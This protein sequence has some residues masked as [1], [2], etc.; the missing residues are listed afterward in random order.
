MYVYRSKFRNPTVEK[1]I[2]QTVIEQFR[3]SFNSF[4]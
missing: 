2:I 4:T 1:A 3:S